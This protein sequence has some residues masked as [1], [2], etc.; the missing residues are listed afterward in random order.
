MNNSATNPTEQQTNADA[1]AYEEALDY[2]YSFIN[3]EA[4]KQDRYMASKLDHTR[5]R[6]LMEALGNPYQQYPAIHIA[7]TK[8]KGSTA[9]MCAFA[10]RAAG[11]TVGLYTSP[12]LQDFRERIRILTPDDADGRIPKPQ[13]VQ[14]INKIRAL[15]A[16]FPDITWFEIL[17]AIAFLHFADSNIDVAVVEVGL[18]GRLD[19]TN[20]I[21]P[22][23]SV[24]TRLSLD[25]T[26]L[27]GNTLDK[28]AYEK[29]GIIKPSI[30]VIT[31]NQEP[32][33]LAKLQAISQERE[34]PL[35]IVE[36]SWEYD[37]GVSMDSTRAV[38]H[39]PSRQKLTI[40]H[41][42]DPDFIPHG[43]QFDLPLGGEHQ[44]ENAT[45]A[46]V[47][48]QHVHTKLPRIT[49]E[50]MQA[51][52]ANVKWPGRLDIIH[53]GDDKTPMLLVDC[54]HNPDSAHKLHEA[55]DHSFKYN[56]LWLIFGAPADKDVLHMLADLLP[57]AHHTTVTT[58]S[59]PR[60]ATPEELAEMSAELGFEVTAV[61]DMAT[62]LTTTWHQAQPGDLICVTGSIVVVGDLLNQ[63]ESLQSQ[64]LNYQV[65]QQ[66]L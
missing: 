31:A 8:G 24:I 58:A 15:E 50:A 22:L 23:V 28:I 25:H 9:A 16:D 27:L 34:S 41:S 6:R 60:S 40:T 1:N 3:F 53:P 51:G 5:P 39:H 43:T 13:F 65:T 62:A 4:K 45:L 14:Q 55:L 33:A 57:L 11:Y 47:A 21:I 49:L 17:T 20:V 61:P 42:L 48:L 35:T 30:P 32:E 46:L 26:A 59:H 19:A 7:G 64:L 44:L 10:L 52:L 63:W 36:Q 56:N 29:G 54:A 2:L 18:G 38:P 66:S 37:G 12:H